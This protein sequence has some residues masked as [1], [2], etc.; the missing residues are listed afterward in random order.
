[1]IS[2]QLLY[3]NMFFALFLTKVGELE[4]RRMFRYV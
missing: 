3:T 1:M 2:P 4:E